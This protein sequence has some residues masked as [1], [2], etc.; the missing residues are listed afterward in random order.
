MQVDDDVLHGC[1]IDVFLAGT[2]PCPFR[3]L[4]I[5]KNTDDIEIVRINEVGRGRGLRLV[6]R[7]QDATMVYLSCNAL[8]E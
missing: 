1:I 4:V 5:W 6:P 2:L 8:P 3:R 7:T